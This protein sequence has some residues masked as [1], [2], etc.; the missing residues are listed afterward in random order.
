MA[1]AMLANG[2][3]AQGLELK[4]ADGLRW[5]CG[6]VGADERRM[7]A[8]LEAETNL[9]LT[10]VT[11]KR[12]GYLA[13]VDLSLSDA[14]S[15]S[16]RLTTRTD[17][18]I[19]LLRLPAGQYRVEA[20]IGGVRRASVVTVP[21]AGKQPARAVFAFPGDPWDGIWASDEEKKQ[22]REP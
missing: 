2:A 7:L 11:V 14:G 18:P 1:F 3:L 19:C 8:P 16:P 15:K 22:A 12:G 17:G 9:A 10:F 20:A 21:V 5:V 4:D 13:D 6:G